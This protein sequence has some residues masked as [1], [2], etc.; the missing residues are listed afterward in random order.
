MIVYAKDQISTSY[1]YV[2]HNAVFYERM[3]SSMGRNVQLCCER[4]SISLA[5]MLLAACSPLE[6][7]MMCAGV[8]WMM[9]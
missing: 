2:S 4:F 7:L 8:K 5:D 1:R 9:M 3:R 6:L